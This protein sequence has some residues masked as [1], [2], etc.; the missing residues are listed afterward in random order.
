VTERKPFATRTQRHEEEIR[1]MYVKQ[2]L[3]LLSVNSVSSV[4]NL[5]CHNH[6]ACVYLVAERLHGKRLDRIGNMG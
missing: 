5:I 6:H 3:R 4:V 2:I 1:K